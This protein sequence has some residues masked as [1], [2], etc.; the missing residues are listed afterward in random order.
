MKSCAGTVLDILSERM[1]SAALRAASEKALRAGAVDD[2]LS[3]VMPG[4]TFYLAAEFRRK[5]PGQNSS[6]GQSRAR[7]WKVF[8]ASIRRRS[9]GSGC[10]RIS[11][12]LIRR[13]RKVILANC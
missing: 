4:E 5:F 13:W 11:G 7:N 10:P 1:V 3:R 2:A 12:F 6:L 8:P 9:A